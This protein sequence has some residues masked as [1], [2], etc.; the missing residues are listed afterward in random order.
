MAR[1]QRNALSWV[2][3]ESRLC[4]SYLPLIERPMEYAGSRRSFSVRECLVNALRRTVF[5]TSV[6]EATCPLHDSHSGSARHA[7]ISLWSIVKVMQLVCAIYPAAKHYCNEDALVHSILR[8][9]LTSD[10]Y[11]PIDIANCHCHTMSPSLA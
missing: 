10:G 7:F 5:A 1:E 8:E 4:R 3:K 6:S 11:Q 9:T 2:K